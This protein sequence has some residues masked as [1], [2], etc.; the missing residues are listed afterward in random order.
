M[1][2]PLLCFFLRCIFFWWRDG[3][4]TLGCRIGGALILGLIP[5][6]VPVGIGLNRALEEELGAAAR[7]GD[8]RLLRSHRVVGSGSLQISARRRR[9]NHSKLRTASD[10]GARSRCPGGLLR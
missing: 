8:V 3:T 6:A 7:V 5:E 9:T 1:T 10:W 2:A 4:G